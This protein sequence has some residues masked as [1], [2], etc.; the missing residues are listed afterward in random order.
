MIFRAGL[1]VILVGMGFFGPHGGAAAEETYTLE[2]LFRAAER[3]S[4]LLAAARDDNVLA[5]A[6][7]EAVKAGK[8]HF[9]IAYADYD[10]GPFGT[11]LMP[12]FDMPQTSW[13]GT[14]E[15]LLE[16]RS[17]SGV[18]GGGDDV[19]FRSM[20]VV[21]RL[22][23][24]GEFENLPAFDAEGFYDALLAERIERRNIRPDLYIPIRSYLPFLRGEGAGSSE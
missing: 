16:A 15:G 14:Y 21:V 5:R 22:L 8:S 10:D 13:I 1:Y 4:P 3:H 17:L 7:G 24:D 6:S 12:E 2:Q 9:V 20:T 19:G 18:N 23:D 11:L